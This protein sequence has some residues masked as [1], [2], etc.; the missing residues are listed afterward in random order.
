MQNFSINNF[1]RGENNPPPKKNF[2]FKLYKKNTIKSLN[3]IEYF[4]NNFQKFVKCFKFS[5]FFK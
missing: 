4:L 3:E 5:K 2:D 1:N